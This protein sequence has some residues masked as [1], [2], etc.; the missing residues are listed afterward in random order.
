MIKVLK[1]SRE[2]WG[3]QVNKVPRARRDQP[4]LK[5]QQAKQAKQ[6]NRDPNGNPITNQD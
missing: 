2:Q 3:Q 1:D 6:A 4:D 5:V